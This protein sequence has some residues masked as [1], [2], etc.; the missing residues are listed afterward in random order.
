MKNSLYRP[1]DG[2]NIRI[3]DDEVVIADI[4]SGDVHQL[5]PTASFIW[6]L[7]DGETTVEQVVSSVVERYEISQA[8]ARQDVEAVIDD[9][10]KLNLFSV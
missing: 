4:E 7:C 1:K 8:Q 3:I 9:L 2:L 6:Q 10:L 5:N